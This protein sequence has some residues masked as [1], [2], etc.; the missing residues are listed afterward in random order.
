MNHSVADHPQS[1]LI[2]EMLLKQ[3]PLRKI[4]ESV[5]PK[6]SAMAL[7]RYKVSVLQPTARA[8]TL[9]KSMEDLPDQRK[10]IQALQSVATVAPHLARI[11]KRQADID[12]TIEA[13]RKEKDARGVAALATADLKGIELAMRATGLLAAPD[14]ASVTVNIV[15]PYAAPAPNVDAP[16]GDD[17]AVTIDVTA[18]K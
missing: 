12:E 17:G 7:Q 18:A 3:V 2:A 8:L 9:A 10:T 1:K 15:C 11:E 5:T 6:V 4:A 13:A 14:A 16:G